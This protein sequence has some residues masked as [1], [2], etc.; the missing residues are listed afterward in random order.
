[1]C[2]DCF[3]SDT[4]A[5]KR[6]QP[7]PEAV[8]ILARGRASPGPRPCAGYPSWPEA[9]AHTTGFGTHFKQGSRRRTSMPPRVTGVTAP[10]QP[11]SACHFWPLPFGVMKTLPTCHGFIATAQ[12]S[13]SSACLMR[14]GHEGECPGGTN[15]DHLGGM[16][17]DHCFARSITEGRGGNNSMSPVRWYLMRRQ[18]IPHQNIASLVVPHPNIP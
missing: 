10:E 7:W 16:N 8:G 18:T 15:G 14:E 11:Y 13:S 2:F 6:L 12:E 17:G 9:E 4:P 1:M 3:L 5:F